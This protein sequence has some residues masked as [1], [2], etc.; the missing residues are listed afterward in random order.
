M[1]GNKVH[2]TESQPTGEVGKEMGVLSAAA[3]CGQN[4]SEANQEARAFSSLQ[5]RSSEEL[6]WRKLQRECAI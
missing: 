1:G 6:M 2:P 4:T 3:S 5:S